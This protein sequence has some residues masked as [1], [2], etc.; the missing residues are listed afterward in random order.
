MTTTGVVKSVFYIVFVPLVI[1][2]MYYCKQDVVCN[3]SSVIFHYSTAIPKSR[4]YCY[5]LYSNYNA[6][7]NKKSLALSLK[8]IRIHQRS[9]P[10][11]SRTSRTFINSLNLT[12]KLTTKN[13]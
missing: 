7:F 2:C 9:I 12:S 3:R 13:M 11:K 6:I 4:V 10:F 1:K 5:K 8:I